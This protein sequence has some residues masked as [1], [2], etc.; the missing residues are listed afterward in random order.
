MLTPSLIIHTMKNVDLHI[1]DK[2]NKL[3]SLSTSSNPHEAANALRKAQKLMEHYHIS[4]DDLSLPQIKKYEL[5]IPRGF[6][7]RKVIIPICNIICK[8]LGLISLF[9]LKNT[10]SIEMVQFFGYTERL[11]QVDYI[12]TY[13][14]RSVNIATDC[15]KEKIEAK[16]QDKITY[17]ERLNKMLGAF[18]YSKIKS[19]EYLVLADHLKVLKRDFASLKKKMMQAYLDGY[20][21]SVYDEIYEINLTEKEKELIY[22]TIQ[23][24]EGDIEKIKGRKKKLDSISYSAYLDGLKDGQNNAIAAPLSRGEET[25]KLTF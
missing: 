7:S 23:D 6:K 17:I 9:K 18:A 24:N 4:D 15:F 11:A 5:I 16:L 10:K 21:Y 3:L 19:K 22:A 2:I 25:I 14:R 1:I 8:T 20:L 13:L 12:F